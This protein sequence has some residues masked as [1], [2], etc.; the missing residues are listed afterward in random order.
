MS[1]F[2]PPGFRTSIRWYWVL[3]SH[4]GAE[5]RTQATVVCSVHGV[6][7]WHSRPSLL[8]VFWRRFGVSWVL[9]DVFCPLYQPVLYLLEDVCWISLSWLFCMSYL[10]SGFKS[11][12][13]CLPVETYVSDVIS[14]DPHHE[15]PHML[16][17]RHVSASWL[18]P[19]ENESNM[20][21]KL[22]YAGVWAVGVS[23]DCSGGSCRAS[24]AFS[25]MSLSVQSSCTSSHSSI[26]PI[27]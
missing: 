23:T 25:W 3:F 9:I 24:F 7:N 4:M 20:S 5:C 10:W 22:R 19:P 18:Q 12:L 11:H 15:H 1:S 21:L 13:T 17:N 14:P 8:P 27:R 26:V 6:F 16:K 2:A